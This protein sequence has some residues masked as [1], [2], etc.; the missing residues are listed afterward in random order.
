MGDVARSDLVVVGAGIVGLAH[1]VEASRRGLDVI[2]LDREPR[3]GGASV[4][5]FGHGFFS[6]Q[7]GDGLDYAMRARERWLELAAAA[8]FWLA[9]SGTLLVARA[10]D[11][12][13]VME[14]F[15]ERSAVEAELLSAARVQELVPIGSGVATGGLL[16]PLDCRIDPREAVGS[17]ARWLVE[18]RGVE[19]RFGTAVRAVEP[20]RV[21]TTAG[22]IEAPA[23]VVCPG[24]DL[25]TLFGGAFAEAGVMRCKLQMLRL[26]ATGRGPIGPALLTGMS[27]LHY[28][29]FAECPSLP[30]YRERLER[31][32]P[33][34]RAAG[35]HILVTQQ[36]DGELIVGDTHE[37]GL[38]PSPFAE[39]RLDRLGLEE[40]RALLGVE[41]LEVRERWIGV[42][43]WSAESD[44][45]TATPIDGVRLVSVTSGI[46]MTTALGLAPSV[47]EELLVGGGEVPAADVLETT[48]PVAR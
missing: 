3:A 47:V 9:E 15:A 39:E 45:L 23:T 41:R 20:G 21:I 37:Y 31:E 33:E 38:A 7:A 36:P 19:I 42:Y 34:L 18:E 46:G 2:V 5:N 44:F 22:E 28:R 6:A 17:I 14:E 32:R 24:P 35:I 13:A 11:E 29:G 40:V 48:R 4:R 1:A 8:G 43:P 10:D 12:L 30:G 25:E 27:A 26:A 16:C